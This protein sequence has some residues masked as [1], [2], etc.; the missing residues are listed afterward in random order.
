M[1]LVVKPTDNK[2]RA[3]GIVL[4]GAIAFVIGAILTWAILSPLFST[5]PPTSLRQNDVLPDVSAFT[6][7]QGAVTLGNWYFDHHDWAKA[8][9]QYRKALSLG[10][11][12]ADVRSDLGTAPRYNNQPEAAAAEY[13]IAQQENPGHENSLFNLATL[14]L[15]SLNQPERAI[16]L[17]EQFRT[18]FPRSGAIPRVDELLQE[19]KKRGTRPAARV[20]QR[21]R[22]GAG[23]SE[24]TI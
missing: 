20:E 2:A 22:R 3:A 23:K 15:Q 13:E 9:E 7:S 17:L 24:C 16:A 1:P 21:L 18:R 12:N 5:C 11:D 6:P 19:A 4:V 10:L 8:T 14:Y